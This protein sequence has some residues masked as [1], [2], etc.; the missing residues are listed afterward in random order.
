MSQS[1]LRIRP[2]LTTVAAPHPTLIHALIPNAST[3]I[4]DPNNPRSGLRG[5]FGPLLR[6]WRFM[7]AF[8]CKPGHAPKCAQ[9][10]VGI[11]VTATLLCL[12]ACG[13]GSG[14]VAGSGGSG[15]SDGSG[16]AVVPTGNTC[17]AAQTPTSA[18][19]KINLSFA[20]EALANANVDVYG[21]N[22]NSA[23]LLAEV[24]SDASG[25]ASVTQ[26]RV[27]PEA[28]ALV[29]VVASGGHRVHDTTPLTHLRYLSV[30][31]PYCTGADCVFTSV[32]TL[33]EFATVLTSVALAQFIHTDTTLS[34]S[35]NSQGLLNAAAGVLSLLEVS[36]AQPKGLLANLSCSTAPVMVNCTALTKLNNLANGMSRCL[37]ANSW[38]SPPCPYTQA[39]FSAKDSV[40]ALVQ[41]IR[42]PQYRNAGGGFY[43][44][45][46]AQDTYN[47]NLTRAPDD[48]SVG[49]DIPLDGLTGTQGMA[50]DQAGN[51]W[52]TSNGASSVAKVA[53][54]GTVLSPAG[55]FS[56]SGLLGPQGLAVDTHGLIWVSSWAQGSGSQLFVFNPDGSAATGSP[57]SAGTLNNNR[58]LLGPIDLALDLNG[59]M[60]VANYSNAT[61]VKYGVSPSGR[62]QVQG[63]PFTAGGLN[64]PVTLAIDAANSVWLVNNSASS[65]SAFSSAGVALSANGFTHIGLNEPA[66]VAVGLKQDIWVSNQV[67]DSLFQ[68]AG[69]NTPPLS[70]P[71][72]PQATD[73]GCVL[74]RI[75]LNTLNFFGPSALA[76]D[77]QGVV[78]VANTLGATLLAVSATGQPVSTVNGY[79]LASMA[80]P[81]A[82]ALD[83]AGNVWVAN[84]GGNSVIKFLGLAAPVK[85]PKQGPPVPL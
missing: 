71:A 42:S 10:R 39:G 41:I 34:L 57:I 16:G 84:G 65:L 43:A 12:A 49:I 51:V 30:L 81:G 63:G 25:T 33:N 64:F 2:A 72:S 80:L 38:L 14:G 47:P 46:S 76:I 55:G 6:L 22:A 27:S 59:Q 17:S 66:G 67:G 5:L 75:D 11:A 83:A 35:G 40:D 45:A 4:T 7:Q 78:F 26:W 21:V 53:T 48:W 60:W 56:A 50:I 19:L 24:Q 31:G 23:C 44:P 1:A 20:G 18:A 28:G 69:G 52:V 79:Q 68:V 77:G 54:D 32:V 8:V 62:F 36:S 15:G 58:T 73:T 74:Q 9:L 70:C 13:G 3:R 29:Y 85:T 61:L 82:L 37:G